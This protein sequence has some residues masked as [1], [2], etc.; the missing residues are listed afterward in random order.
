MVIVKV[1]TILYT[2]IALLISSF[3]FFI[4]SPKVYDP[5]ELYHVYLDGKSIGHVYSKNELEK[6]IDT[7]EENIKEQYNVDKVYI[8]NNLDIVKEVTY[9]EKVYSAKSIYEEIKDKASFTIKG[10]TITIKGV[11]EMTEEGTVK[12]DDIVINVLDKQVFIDAVNNTIEAFVDEEN[13][14]DFLNNSQTPITDTGSIIEDV[15]VQN[16]ILIKEANISIKD[17]IFLNS[18]DLSKYL[19]FGTL[20]EQEKYIVKPGDTIES[21]SFNNRL[22]VGEFLI[23]NTEF[24]SADNLLYAGQ[25]VTLGVVKPAVKVV[26]EDYVVTIENSNYTIVYEDDDTLPIGMEIVKQKGENG[27]NKVT[28][29]L[30]VING[31]IR[32]VEPLSQEEIKPTISQI[33]I[34]GQKYVSNIGNPRVWVWPTANNYVISSPFGWRWGKLH[35]GLDI[36]G[37]GNGSPIYA[38]NNGVVEIAEWNDYNGYYIYI[39]HNNGYYSVYGHMSSLNVSPGQVVEAGQVIGGMG[40]TGF[41]FG[42]HL[43]FS[44]FVGNPNYGGTAVNPLQF[45]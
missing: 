38:A 9:N 11:E 45:Y 3:I 39:N 25:V 26:E 33:I 34:R 1:K 16:D 5:Q 37:P 21:V 7:E 19:L 8:P 22:S 36:S 31:D 43:H 29:R 10:Y 12:N 14:A 40:E 13:Y 2:A 35:E 30:Q 15:Y 27:I 41:A 23:S 44:I 24:N 32:G 17:Q 6:Y 42:V 18:E 20:D 28:R 4:N